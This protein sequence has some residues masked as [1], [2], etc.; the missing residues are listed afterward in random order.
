MTDAYLDKL[1]P[2]SNVLSQPFARGIVASNL[3][4][5]SYAAASGFVGVFI[6]RDDQPE[7]ARRAARYLRD[8]FRE[9]AQE[10]CKHIVR[11]VSKADG[12]GKCLASFRHALDVWYKNGRKGVEPYSAQQD[13]GSCVDASGSEGDT[14]LVGWRAANPEVLQSWGEQPEEYIDPVAWY[15]YA[16]RE[17]CSDGWNGYGRAKV[18]LQVGLAFRRAYKIGENSID[19]TDDDKNEQIVARG[20]CRSGIPAWLK[21]FTFANHPFAPDAIMEFEGDQAEML[22][23]FD[24][25]GYI[26]TSGTRTS[27]GS[28]PFLIGSVGPHMQ[29]AHGGDD[30]DHCRKWCKEVWKVTPRTNDFPVVMGQTW[31]PWSKALNPRLWPVGTDASGRVW[32]MAEIIDRMK[33][34]T[35]AQAFM[36]E[37]AAG[38]GWG[39]QPQGAWVWWASDVLKRLSCDM[40]YRPRVRG[41]KS[42]LPPPPPPVQKAPLISGLLHGELLTNGRIVIRGDLAMDKWRYIA[43]PDGTD[44]ENFKIVEKP[45]L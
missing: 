17:Y 4:E 8:E 15:D 30:S 42:T 16:N 13:F 1:I 10:A 32:T 9:F 41:F 39:L 33:A 34:G 31:G 44:Q 29:T 14:Q 22:A 21:G 5:A 36:D 28:D 24:E 23:V 43:V 6:D 26:H 20:W 11:S 2:K 12:H 40:A 37:L 27:G 38:W 45:A 18:A 25:G 35:L 19:F 3:L 7:W